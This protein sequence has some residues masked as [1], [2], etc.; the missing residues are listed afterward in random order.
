MSHAL[1]TAG[2]SFVRGIVS[3]AAPEAGRGTRPAA[4]R[5]AQARPQTRTMVATTAP[6]EAA[7]GPKVIHRK[8]Y[9]PTPYLIDTVHLDFDLNEDATTVTARLAMTPNH[10][11]P[12]PPPLELNGRKDVRLVGLKVKGAPVPP[13][14]YSLT[15]KTLTL[16]QPPAGAYELEIVT[17]IKPQENSDLEGLYKSSGNY[18]TQCEAEGFRGITFFPDRPDVMAKWAPLCFWGDPFP[19]PCYL[20]AL[21]AGDLQVKEDSFKTASGRDV[22]LRIYT[23]PQYIDQVDFA[24]ES[25]KKSMKWDEEVYGLEYDLVGGF[26]HLSSGVTCRDW[27]QLTLKEGLTVFRDQEFSSDMNSRAVKRIED[28]MRLR[29]AQFSEDSGP[30]AHPIR[31]DSYIKMDNFYTVTVYEKA[32]GGGARIVGV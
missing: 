3:R 17:S 20:F 21:V 12:V 9:K 15:D 2:R 25:L 4:S 27:F 13:S 14:G 28:A 7:A 1:A 29:A 18:C 16:L 23:Q 31:P 22:A 8:D 19:K 24:M 5:F 6:A 26:S 32:R 11:D 30:M 10:S